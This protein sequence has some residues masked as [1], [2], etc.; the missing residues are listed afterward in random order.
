MSKY[1]Q[2]VAATALALA[3]TSVAAQ[4]QSGV[5]K[6]AATLKNACLA[7]W[8]AFGIAGLQLPSV[9]IRQDSLG[10]Q[11]YTFLAEPV[12][13]QTTPASALVVGDIIEAVNGRP[14]TTGAGAHQLVHPTA[15]QSEIRVRR[16]R[17]RHTVAATI[18]PMP[19]ECDR[20]TSSGNGLLADSTSMLLRAAA[21]R[22]ESAR[23]DGSTPTP[24]GDS[25]AVILKS[26]I[27]R[28]EAD[29]SVHA[30]RDQITLHPSPQVAADRR[31]SS[32]ALIIVDGVVLS[33]SSARPPD[34]D[35]A[36][37]AGF[38]FAVA[39]NASCTATT[40]AEGKTMFT[41]YKYSVYPPI[42]AVRP[43]GVAARAGIKVGDVVT[44]I[45]GVSVL[46]DNGALKLGSARWKDSVHLTVLRD[47]KEVGYLLKI[48]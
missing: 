29:S 20:S 9:E 13:L 36:S 22:L 17:D 4:Q 25:L 2:I 27:K 6:F 12:V 39:C 31:R 47:S 7:G 14:I 5:G 11:Q 45:D 37:T 38:G 44:K 18:P 35:N 40:G 1:S 3:G 23:R 41:Y 30:V 33:D 16:G 10:R 26:V 19:A 28:L 15:G 48:R 24:A 46:D 42:I 21:A 43:D 8:D 34:G 32:A